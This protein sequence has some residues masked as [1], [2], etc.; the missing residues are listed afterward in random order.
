MVKISYPKEVQ[1]F[2]DKVILEIKMV[3][4]PDFIIIAGSFGKESWVYHKNELISDFEFVFIS[5]KKWSFK[6]KNQLLK[7]LNHEYPF[8]I[9]LK[10]YLLSKVTNKIISNKLFR[11]VAQ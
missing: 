8:E 1:I 9:S 4:D 6:R 7:K 3:L 10:G 2:F 11:R 5:K